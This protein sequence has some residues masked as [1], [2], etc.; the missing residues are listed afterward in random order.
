MR[1]P[2]WMASVA[3]VAVMAGCSGSDWGGIT[4][5]GELSGTGGAADAADQALGTTPTVTFRAA[6]DDYFFA[7]QWRFF[8]GPACTGNAGSPFNF[9]AVTSA[10]V[11]FAP[12]GW[13]SMEVTAGSIS[14]SGDDFA[15]WSGSDGLS[16]VD[17]TICVPAPV[18]PQIYTATYGDAAIN[19]APTLAEIGDQSVYE[20]ATLAFDASA[21]DA[22]TS[23]EALTW[24]LVGAP[25]GAALSDAGSFTWTPAE[26]DGPGSYSFDVCV[27]DDGVPPLS[28]CET[29]AVDVAEVN[30]APVLEMIASQDVDLGS[31]VHFT[32]VASDS[33]LPAN[34]LTFS[35]SGAPSGA[36]IDPST[37]LFSWTATEAGDV[38]FDV[39]VTDNGSPAMSASRGVLFSVHATPPEIDDLMPATGTAFRVGT[40]VEVTGRFSAPSSQDWGTCRAV[41]HAS[42]NLEVMGSEG[43]GVGTCSSM[44]ELVRA[45]VYL[46]TYT[47]IDEQGMSDEVNTTIVAYDPGAGMLVANGW[48]DA[49][50]SAEA[51][52]CGLVVTKCMPL[53]A[54]A[55]PANR[56][57]FNFNS[58]YLGGAAAPLGQVSFRADGMG[59]RFFGLHQDWL[60]VDAQNGTAALSGV[61]WML[62]SSEIYGFRVELYQADGAGPDRVHVTIWRGGDEADVVYDSGPDRPLGGGAIMIVRKGPR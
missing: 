16:S 50:P 43:T 13:S 6:S 42:A 22:E 2:V 17:P 38:A 54:S 27:A 51:S 41:A 10:G 18:D 24:S 59:L 25:T 23:D 60:V 28:D 29:I 11:A 61:G 19:T 44:L 5:P 7:I 31:V 35:L 45:G 40:M 49:E 47:V 36:E 30:T 56:A 62:G 34:T 9:P 20:G 39:V 26:S 53:K 1:L 3:T 12:I 33:D 4:E 14:S 15:N 32:A 57:L 21:S 48:F 37:G 8:D 55:S 46:V 58:R 52:G